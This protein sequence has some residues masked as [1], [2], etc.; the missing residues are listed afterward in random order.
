MSRKTMML[1]G[2][3][4]GV[5]LVASLALA[6]GYMG[7]PDWGHGRGMAYWHAP[8]LTPEQMAQMNK[9]RNDYYNDSAAVRGQLAAKHAEL[10][11]LTGNPDAT[12]AQIAAKQK[13]ILQIRTQFGEKR[14]AYE[15]KLR[16]VLTK[17]Q[18]TQMA[19]S[20]AYGCGPGG[21]YHH[22]MGVGPGWGMGPGPGYHPGMPG[23]PDTGPN[24]PQQQ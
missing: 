11:A 21:R 3:V 18:L 13:E 5:L 15:A 20:P 14:I 7:G 8:N 10:R 6:Q 9:F 1:V 16:S 12:P 22:G 4:A 19:T 23:G 17:D 24:P 2:L